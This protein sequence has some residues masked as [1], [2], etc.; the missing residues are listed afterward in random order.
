MISERKDKRKPNDARLK[1]EYKKVKW[2][3]SEWTAPKRMGEKAP[4][5]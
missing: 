4:S 2:S 5:K 1:R 3:E